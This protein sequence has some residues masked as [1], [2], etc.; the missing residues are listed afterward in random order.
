MNLLK[1]VLSNIVPLEDEST[2]VS[3]KYILRILSSYFNTWKAM[4]TSFSLSPRHLLVKLLAERF[5][6]ATPPWAEA[7]L[8]AARARASRVLPVPGG[9]VSRIDE[10]CRG[11]DLCMSEESDSLLSHTTLSFLSVNP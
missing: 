3:T 9:P 2:S 5:R 1:T 4:E 11:A 8:C 10:V 6:K 7:T